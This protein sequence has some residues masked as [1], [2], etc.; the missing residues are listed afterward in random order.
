MV[1]AAF[2]RVNHARRVEFGSNNID[3]AEIIFYLVVFESKI[4]VVG[5]ARTF[6]FNVNSF[7]SLFPR[8]CDFN[9]VRYHVYFERRAILYLSR[10]KAL[11]NLSWSEMY[12]GHESTKASSLCIAKISRKTQ[13]KRPSLKEKKKRGK[14]GRGEENCNAYFL[15][16]VVEEIMGLAQLLVTMHPISR[17]YPRQK[18]DFLLII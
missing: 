7:E 11:Q 8:N 4:S 2:Q 17:D 9:V 10:I 18:T 3:F 5:D 12:A 13:A 14:E 16:E 1:T 15:V 6:G